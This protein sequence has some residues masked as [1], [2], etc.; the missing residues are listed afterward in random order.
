[1]L[2][3]GARSEEQMTDLENDV[4][5]REW[6]LPHD[7]HLGMLIYA[8]VQELATWL[9]YRN[10]RKYAIDGDDEALSTLLQYV[11]VD[12]RA[13]FDFF[14]RCVQIHM[15][16]DRDATLEQL[17]R[18]LNNFAMPAIYDLAES[19]ARLAQIKE[20]QIFDEDIYYRE[21]YLPVLESL[22]VSRAEIRNRVPKKKSAVDA[23]KF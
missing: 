6:N 14:R 2:R 5:Q 4:F 19:R 18:V 3:S 20:L 9:N 1:L 10:L 22:G 16:H 11:A 15:E 23:A 12:E 13:H 8:M 7:S 17:R 21:V